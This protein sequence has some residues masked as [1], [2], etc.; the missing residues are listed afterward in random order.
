MR[1]EAVAD[2]QHVVFGSVVSMIRP[3]DLLIVS[4][5][6]CLAGCTALL[7]TPPVRNLRRA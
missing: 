4:A 7:L 1:V 3:A 2:D 5:G 6:V